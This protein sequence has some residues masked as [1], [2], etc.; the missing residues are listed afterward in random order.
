[1]TV[2]GA[3]RL[4]VLHDDNVLRFIDP[5]QNAP[6]STETCT[7]EASQFIPER[8]SN[9][10]GDFKERAGDELDRSGGH[11]LRKQFGDRATSRA[12]HSELVR[13]IAQRLRSAS[14]ARAAPVP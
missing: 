4:Y 8:F 6:L 14:S 9:A 10:I 5:V 3:T 1:V 11:V 7:V 2:R 13:L 12:C